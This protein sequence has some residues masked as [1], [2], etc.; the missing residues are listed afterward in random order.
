MENTILNWLF[1]LVDEFAKFGAWLTS[2]LPYIHMP[3]LALFGFAGLV[4]IIT[5]LLLR[6]V[7]GG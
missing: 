7:V 3:P 4:A 6:L 1:G 5:F 2:D